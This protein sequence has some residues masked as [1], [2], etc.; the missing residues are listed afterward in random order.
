[1]V[2]L[3]AAASAA[4]KRKD[5]KQAQRIVAQI[6][7]ADYQGDRPALASLHQE[8]APEPES[9]EASRIYY[10]RGF[11]LWRRAMNGFNDSADPKD[12]ET[13]LNGAIADFEDAIARDPHF[14]DA[15]SAEAG[16]RMNLLFL[17]M[18]DQQYVKE[19]LP[20]LAQLLKDAQAQEPENPRV[21]WVVGG[22]LWYRPVEAG[23]GQDKAMETYQRGL[24]AIRKQAKKASA[25]DPLDPT[26]GEPE[27]L[28]NLAWSN[29]NRTQPDLDA[30]DRYAHAALEMVPDWH[31]LRDILVPQIAKARTTLR[32]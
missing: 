16:C 6:V 28:M 15:E 24:E 32:N 9:P 18:K 21:L 19:Q 23:G 11:A 25:A 5:N 3:A 30:A 4:D 22:G 12:L 8:L 26:W 17:K 1:L 29:L 27:L 7:R 10:W 2:L 14:A 20:K 13:D 31:Y